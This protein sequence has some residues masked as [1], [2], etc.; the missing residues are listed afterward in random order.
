[1][2]KDRGSTFAML[3]GFALGVRRFFVT[4]IAASA[5]SILFNF[6]TPQIIR[7]TVD[8][9]IGAAPLE[10]PRMV[11][12]AL[13][14]LGGR[15]FLRAHFIFCALAIIA[16]S[17]FSGLFNYVSRVSI[18]KGTEGFTKKLRDTLFSHI[19]RLPFQWHTETQTGDIIQRCTSDVE[20]VRNFVSTQLIEVLQ[21]VVLVTAALA[22]MFAM[23]ITLALVSAAFIPVIVLYSL[24]FYRRIAAQFL[25]ADEAEGELMTGIQENLTAVR[26][27]RAFGREK[28]EKERFTQKLDVFTQKW[29]DLGYTLGFFWGV[30]DLVTAGQILAVVCTGAFLAAGGR[31]TLGE[32][33]AFISY[34]YAIS[35]P[36]RTL[37]RT[38]SELS[39]AGVSITRLRE[40]L[41]APPEHNPPA[42]AKPDLRGNIRFEGVS[43]KYGEQTVLE[44][45]SFHIP[46]GSTFGILGATGSGKSTIAYLLNRLYELPEDEGTISVGGADIRGI[47]RH[48]LRRGIGLVLQ[49]PFLFSK[50]LR[51]NIE[52]AAEAGNPELVRQNAE[53]AALDGSMREFKDGYDTMVGERGVTLSGGQKQRVAIARTLMMDCPILVFDDSMSNLDMETDEKIRLSLRQN[54]A[55]K[56]VILISHRISALMQ[57]DQ[58]LVLENGRP[59][60]L[61]SH[62]ELM[63]EDGLYRRVYQMQSDTM[64]LRG[65]EEG[66]DAH[67]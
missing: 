1:M 52:I 33:L 49:E 63:A 66:S 26:V 45:I 46:A 51:E 22:L 47:D 3:N 53:I 55:G 17:L 6:L 43:F 58:I 37:G 65:I 57:A 10:L 29:I 61:G 38:L 36:V 48:H 7:L 44:D 25:Q 4:A 21:T 59:A 13:N 23:N 5:L 56:T 18:A 28:Y 9:V 19:Q 20:T 40:I 8:F 60:Q 39:K 12:A 34:T 42:A 31:I 67:A 14:A 15:A 41:D 16:C 27:V 35:W 30:G 2:P 62:A 50:T 11:T 54:T 24:L 64:L 32:L